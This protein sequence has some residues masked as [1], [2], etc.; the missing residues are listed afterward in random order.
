M[1]HKSHK[2]TG[3][4]HERAQAQA[5][6]WVQPLANTVTPSMHAPQTHQHQPQNSNAMG[7]D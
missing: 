1:T 6:A 2:M 5:S 7:V 4:G 3:G